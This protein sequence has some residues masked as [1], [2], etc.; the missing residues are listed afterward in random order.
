M[1]IRVCLSLVPLS[2]SEIVTV[3]SLCN[4]RHSPKYSPCEDL[5]LAI[6][7]LL[8]PFLDNSLGVPYPSNSHIK[9][10]GAF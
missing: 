9:N 10:T 5:K 3:L 4:D 1:F 7:T 2:Y 6:Q 8:T